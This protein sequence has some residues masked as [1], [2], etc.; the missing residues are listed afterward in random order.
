M[1]SEPCEQ[2]CAVFAMIAQVMWHMR[3]TPHRS[4]IEGM[5]II[6]SYVY[7]LLSVQSWLNWVDEDD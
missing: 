6:G 2:D 4:I 5:Y 3:L 7:D 1:G